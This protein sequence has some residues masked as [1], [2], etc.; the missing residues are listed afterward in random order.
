MNKLKLLNGKENEESFHL[1]NNSKY[2]SEYFIYEDIN[3]L[4]K[5]KN[6]KEKIDLVFILFSSY[7]L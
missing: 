2:L 1:K 7:F 4:I 5:N 3:N 6:E